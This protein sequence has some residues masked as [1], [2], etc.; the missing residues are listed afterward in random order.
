MPSLRSLLEYR[1]LHPSQSVLL[2]T[3]A[4]CL[5]VKFPSNTKQISNDKSETNE[6][7]SV[8]GMTPQ[9][10]DSKIFKR[11]LDIINRKFEC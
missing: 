3:I 2:Q 9:K 7:L 6:I 10:I 5:G 11:D 1:K 8:P 4:S